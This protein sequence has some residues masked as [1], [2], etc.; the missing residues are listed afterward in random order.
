MF[1]A[2]ELATS[3]NASVADVKRAMAAVHDNNPDIGLRG[4][5]ISAMFP[6]LTEMQI[7]AVLSALLDLLQSD[8]PP[9]VGPLRIAI[10]MLSSDHEITSTVNLIRRTA[11]QASYYCTLLRVIQS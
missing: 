4:C 7:R 3:M 11:K 8:S 1:K 2:A 9:P 5:R 6:F 10:P